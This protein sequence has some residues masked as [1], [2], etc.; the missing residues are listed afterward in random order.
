MWA[1]K[2]PACHFTYCNG[3]LFTF[4]G[5]YKL[6]IFCPCNRKIKI[7]VYSKKR[8]WR[9]LRRYGTNSNRI[10]KALLWEK[11][12]KNILYRSQIHRLLHL[13][14]ALSACGLLS[15]FHQYP[16][17]RKCGL[18]KKLCHSKIHFNS[19]IAR[20]LLKKKQMHYLSNVAILSVEI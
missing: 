14:D 20:N 13:A 6:D 8:N 1:I 10:W 18:I 5:I 4:V 17:E 19:N 16:I 7:M 12:V 11:P 9:I 2:F 3:R 15:S